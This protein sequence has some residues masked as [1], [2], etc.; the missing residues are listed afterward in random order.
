M[1]NQNTAPRNTPDAVADET[2]WRHPQT[3]ELLVSVRGLEVK[4][5]LAPSVT[6]LNITTSKLAGVQP[7]DVTVSAPDATTL[8]SINVHWGDG[9]PDDF[10]TAT[11]GAVVPSEGVEYRHTYH[12]VGECTLKVT[13]TFQDGNTDTVAK[14]VKIKA[15]AV[16]KAT[17]K[18]KAEEA[19]TEA[20]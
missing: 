13:A 1:A 17:P 3:G 5:A 19:T 12:N 14:L 18:L 4:K 6:K 2:G 11:L 20:K 10:I 9:S 15:P 7:L 16:A 8:T